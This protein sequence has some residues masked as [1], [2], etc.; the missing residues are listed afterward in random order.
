MADVSEASTERH[1]TPP[2]S[3]PSATASPATVI[4]LSLTEDYAP[5]WGV[6]EG[7]RELVQNWHDGCLEQTSVAG[8]I[9]WESHADDAAGALQRFEA[10]DADGGRCGTALYDPWLQRLTL[11]NRDVSLERRVLLLGTSHKAH[12][13]ESIGQFGE[14]MKV[15]ALALLRER[16]SVEMVTRDERWRW[17]RRADPAF[18]EVRVLSVEVS[19]RDDAADALV[20]AELVGAAAEDD[21]R[22]AADP[23]LAVSA[24]SARSYYQGELRLGAA[25]TCTTV[26]PLEPEE[27]R[28]FAR[29]FLF[30]APPADSFRCELG[31][32]LLPSPTTTN[33]NPNPTPTP[34][35][36]QV[37]AGRAAPGRGAAGPALRQG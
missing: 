8:R 34:N 37:R 33:P 26:S 16:R 17:V 1:H 35:P 18:G 15:G 10:V 22:A 32:L 7:V 24:A 36:D 31:E 23:A 19:R 28:T 30:L 21:E 25:D 11:V 13:A 29:R 4:P 27:W 3:K 2:P 14:G 5:A 20:A 12:A 9:R 6:W